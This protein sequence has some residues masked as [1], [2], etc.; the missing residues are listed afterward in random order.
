M[1]GSPSCHSRPVSNFEQVCHSPPRQPTKRPDTG[2]GTRGLLSLKVGKSEPGGHTSTPSG[3]KDLSSA[4]RRIALLTVDM[5]NDFV[6]GSLA[7]NGNAPTAGD[8]V[9]LFNRLRD[10][11]PFDVVAHSQD[12]H[13]ADHCS[14]VENNPGAELFH[15]VQIPT[16][17]GEG[18]VPQLMWPTHCVQGSSGARFHPELAGPARASSR[19]P[20]RCRSIVPAGNV[21][22]C[23]SSARDRPDPAEGHP[24]RC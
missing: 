16:P 8:C 7:V 17:D 21:T 13:P 24:P 5:Q 23:S 3:A 19:Q 15:E 12:W 2:V 14:F 1:G 6:D 4:P 20:L 10:A 11:V 22:T 9:R 18:T